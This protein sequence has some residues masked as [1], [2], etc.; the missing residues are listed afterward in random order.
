MA[1]EVTS[2]TGQGSKCI[3]T[4]D[5]LYNLY[6]NYTLT[7]H[8]FTLPIYIFNAHMYL[9]YLYTYTKNKLAV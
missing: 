9:H 5:T 7:L 2:F 6:K 4:V 8:I 3:S 1:H